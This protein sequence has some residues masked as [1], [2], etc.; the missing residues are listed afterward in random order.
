MHS[1]HAQLMLATAASLP[2]AHDEVADRWPQRCQPLRFLL[3]HASR[4][5]GGAVTCCRAWRTIMCS[6]MHR[7]AGAIGHLGCSAIAVGGGDTSVTIAAANDW[8][9]M[10]WARS[11]AALLAAAA[12]GQLGP[13][14]LC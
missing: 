7:A 13:K 8:A 1:K 5:A 6:I 2:A 10:R 12:V 14:S 3:P 11:L 9:A 4:L